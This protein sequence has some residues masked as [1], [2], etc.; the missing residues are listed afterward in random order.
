[1]D[2]SELYAGQFLKTEDV[3]S[4]PFT[5]TVKSAAVKEMQDG[6]RRVVIYF[7]G[8]ARGLVLNKTRY[9][10]VCE[11]AKSSNTDNWRGLSL[12]VSAATTSFGGKRVGCIEVGKGEINDPLPDFAA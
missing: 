2:Y 9:Q 11:I 4:K 3:L 5:G 8:M 7:D 1:M 6:T 10:T 12:R